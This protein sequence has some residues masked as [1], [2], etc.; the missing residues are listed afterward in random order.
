MSYSFDRTI[1]FDSVRSRLFSGKLTQQQ[2]DGQ[3]HILDV[4]ERFHTDWDM[5]WLAYALATTKHETAS[6]M[7]PIEEYG[8]GQG[9]PYGKPDPETK[10]TYYGRGLVQLTWRDNYQRA[11]NELDL[12]GKDDLVWH[13][14]QA[15]DPDLASAIMFQGM[16]AGWFRSDSKGKQTLDRY[17]NAAT[18]DPFNARDII[19]GD[20]KTVPSWSNGLNI[21]TL[22]KDYH[23]KFFAALK[24]SKVDSGKP[25]PPPPTPEPDVWVKIE[26]PDS[27]RL[28]VNGQEVQF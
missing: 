17:F 8:K 23:E 5:R 20:K 24:A 25:V 9:M 27:V 28:M 3:N 6:T 11:T 21:G 12:G 2:V 7:W 10:Q 16:S 22:I 14:E 13:P 26:I 4:W 18:D 19:N 15:L 1:Y